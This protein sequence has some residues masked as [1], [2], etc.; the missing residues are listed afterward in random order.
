[1]ELANRIGDYFRNRPLFRRAVF[2]FL[3]PLLGGLYIFL[4]W[5][6]YSLDVSGTILGAMTAYFFPPLG[7]ESVIPLSVTWLKSHGYPD[8]FLNMVVVPFSVAFIDIVVA[9]FLA[10]NFDLA[11]KIPIL[12]KWMKKMEDAGR[13]RMERSK[14][15]G[16]LLFW[17]IVA[18]VMVP[19][20]GSGGVA[21]TILGRLAGLDWKRTVLAISIGAIAGCFTIGI[22]SYYAADALIE[23]TGGSTFKLAA[24]LIGIILL[25]LL[26]FWFISNR[27]YITDHIR[28][29][30]HDNRR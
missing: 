18:F 4:L 25:I 16:R 14:W 19:F 3:P 27:K 21:A 28:G 6:S 24:L 30:M 23:A 12:G 29:A 2:F 20:Q 15:S 13:K 5:A 8:L 1:M 10:W 17:G 9:L 7:K 11:L 22:I 26:I